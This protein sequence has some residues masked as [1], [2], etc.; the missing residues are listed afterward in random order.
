M[1]ETYATTPANYGITAETFA[2]GLH[3]SGHILT[4]NMTLYSYNSGT[5]DS[6]PAR[7]CRMEHRDPREYEGS[8]CHSDGQSVVL[9]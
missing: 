6:I 7:C 8:G 4:H 3:I 1:W 5:C 2:A 9:H